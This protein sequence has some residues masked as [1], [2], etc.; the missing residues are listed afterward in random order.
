MIATTVRPGAS[1]VVDDGIDQDCSGADRPEDACDLDGDGFSALEGDCDDT[2]RRVFPGAFERCNGRD[3]NCVDGVDEGYEVGA[4]CA[5][6]VG[7]CRNAS[8]LRCSADGLGRVC[9]AVPGL[10]EAETCDGIDNDCN[11]AVDDV[12]LAGTADVDNCGGCNVQCVPEANQVPACEVNADGGFGCQFDC[13]TGFIDLNRESADGCEYACIITNGGEEVC[14]G[15][16]NDCDGEVDEG[17][18]EFR[19]MARW[20]LA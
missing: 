8:T 7:A 14:D 11:Q 9:G 13:A 20:K 12:A 18:D 10:P 16:D 2:N 15:L 6:G 3:D 4:E 17:T 19:T 1:E 5:V